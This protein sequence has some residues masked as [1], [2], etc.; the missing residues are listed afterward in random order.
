MIAN[1][2]LANLYQLLLHAPLAHAQGIQAQTLSPLTNAARNAYQP[3]AH[4]LN[5]LLG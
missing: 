4:P 2:P 3:P 1:Q 5:A